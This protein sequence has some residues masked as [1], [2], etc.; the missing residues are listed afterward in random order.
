MIGLYKLERLV[1]AYRINN[2]A[3]GSAYMGKNEIYDE[4]LFRRLC[5]L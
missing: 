5:R 4:A 1:G 3:I 2:L